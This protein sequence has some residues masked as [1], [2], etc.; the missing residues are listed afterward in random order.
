MV[1]RKLGQFETFDW[2]RFIQG[3]KLLTTGA[4]PWLEYADGAQTGKILGTV[5][6]VVIIE[7]RTAY[8]L[9]EGEAVSN[10]FE[11]M[12][13]KLPVTVEVPMDREV[14][15]EGVEAKVYGDYKT[16]LSVKAQAVRA[17]DGSA[18]PKDAQ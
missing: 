10:R 16:E 6:E 14:V 18:K 9:K 3:K 12:R 15:F 8:R 4:K 7:D 11:K 17:V 5:I 2:Q 1:L 13:V